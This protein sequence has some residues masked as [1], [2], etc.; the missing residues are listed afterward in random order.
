MDIREI[1]RL[2]SEG[3]LSDNPSRNSLLSL[4]GK[5]NL[6]T[7]NPPYF[8][9][10]TGT[11][12]GDSQ[13]RNARFE[14]HGGIEE[15][16]LA[17]REL[18]CPEN[19]LFVFSFCSSSVSASDATGTQCSDQ[20]VRQALA[21]AGLKLTR[22]TMVLAGRWDS[23]EP[24]GCVYEAVVAQGEGM[25]DTFVVEERQ[26]DI[27]RMETSNRL[28]PLYYSIQRALNMAPRPLKRRKRIVLSDDAADSI[29]AT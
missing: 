6:L 21:A 20:R 18:L 26:L 29:T 23:S 25:D 3:I 27:R 2:I 22:R 16:C 10:G 8:P 4:K 12:S 14:L 24:M 28:N 9:R 17:A 13:L 5:C 1:P 15:Y 11:H 19:G 7:A